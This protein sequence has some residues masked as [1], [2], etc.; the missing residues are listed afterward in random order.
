MYL[1]RRLVKLMV[2]I[3]FLYIA[4]NVHAKF[5]VLNGAA[6]PFILEEHKQLFK[7]SM[8]TAKLQYEFVD[9]PGVLHGFTNPDA[10]AK[11]EQFSLPLKYDAAADQASWQKMQAFLQSVF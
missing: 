3:S 7:T 10:T 11:G 8:Q 2:V 6:D 9:Y 5:L 1:F 4:P